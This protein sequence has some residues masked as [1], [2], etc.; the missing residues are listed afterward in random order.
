MRIPKILFSFLLVV[1]A[2]TALFTAPVLADESPPAAAS[3]AM[4]IFIN[5]AA[6]ASDVL[7]VDESTV[8]RIEL[9]EGLEYGLT[10]STSPEGIREVT[11][12]IWVAPT[13]E[14]LGLPLAPPSREG[15]WRPW[16]LL[17]PLPPP[18]R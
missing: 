8:V 18:E 16:W 15:K 13:E 2:I 17:A 12:Y 14:T 10:S 3:A 5:D 7:V 6:G 9:P 4:P 1:V 11:L